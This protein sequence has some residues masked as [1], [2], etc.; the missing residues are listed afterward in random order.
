MLTNCEA[1]IYADG[2]TLL[3]EHHNVC[4]IL[5][6]LQQELVMLMQ[7]FSA[8]KLLL[9]LVKTQYMIFNVTENAF[10]K[11][12]KLLPQNTEMERVRLAP[13]TVHELFWMI[14]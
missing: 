4:H 2:T 8:S 12:K 11:I 6:A 7:W 9:N 5:E 3:Y 13:S 1:I 10:L 14:N